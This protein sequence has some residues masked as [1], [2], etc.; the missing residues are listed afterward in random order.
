[1]SKQTVVLDGYTLNPGDLSWDPLEQLVGKC[2][3]HDRTPTEDVVD[4]ARKAEILLT[5]KTPLPVEA[6]KNLPDLK[7]VGVLATGFNIVDVMTASTLGITV[8]NIPN[9]GTKS[10][11]Q[12]TMAL[13]LELAQRVGSHS[14]SVKGGDWIR[15]PDFC[16]W[17]HP[18]LELD[19]LCMGIVGYGRIGQEVANMARSFG[20]RI[21]AVQRDSTDASKHPGVTFASLDEVIREADV[22]S[23]HCPL[24]TETQFLMNGSRLAAMK[25]T[26][27]LINTSRGPLVDERA[28]ADALMAGEIAGAGI[29]VVELEPPKSES[30]LYQA[31]NCYITPHIA[32]ATKAARSRLL[33]TAVENIRG[34]LDGNPQN[35]VNP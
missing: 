33:H 2:E 17:Q 28:L 1:M 29:D 23:L 18:L 8:T 6:L 26:A 34:Y 21:V 20:M 9:Y 30:L 32:W 16:Y 19:G 4:R 11:A 25:S 5:N 12:M 14:E 35:V 31:P 10:V 3:I 15:C 22:L 7:Y 24:T 27:L 13:L